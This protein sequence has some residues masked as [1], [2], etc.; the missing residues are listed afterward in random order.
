MKALN[1]LVG[2]TCVIVSTC[3]VL[4][5]KEKFDDDRRLRE[6]TR[7]EPVSPGMERVDEE[8]SDSKVI[9]AEFGPRYE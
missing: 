2:V 9:E 5:I 1:V 4:Y 6:L 3:G 8:T 7:H